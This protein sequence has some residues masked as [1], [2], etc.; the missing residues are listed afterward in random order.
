MV[1]QPRKVAGRLV[2]MPRLEYRW[3]T[4]VVQHLVWSYRLNFPGFA[5]VLLDLDGQ[6][7]SASVPFGKRKTFAGLL[8]RAGFDV[9]EVVHRGW[10]APAPIDADQHS[11][12]QG[13]VPR[14]VLGKRP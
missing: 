2:S 3:P 12:L 8:R 9:V 10:E 7:A 13:R 4:V 5:S 11:Q 6:L 1:V 14:C